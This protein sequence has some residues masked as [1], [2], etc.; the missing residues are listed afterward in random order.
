MTS[1]ARL[2]KE[3]KM[4]SKAHAVAHAVGAGLVRT[5]VEIWISLSTL[6][7]WEKAISVMAL[8]TI[9]EKGVQPDSLTS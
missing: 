7:C 3:I 4:L 8:V 6:K 9:G 2:Q 1:A 5:C